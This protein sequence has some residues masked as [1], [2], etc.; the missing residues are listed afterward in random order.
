MNRNA[1]C[2]RRSSNSFNYS[3]KDYFIFVE[4]ETKKNG[5]A[6]RLADFYAKLRIIINL[7]KMRQPLISAGLVKCVTLG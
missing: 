2:R 4:W 7:H 5:D 6:L 1:H 3:F